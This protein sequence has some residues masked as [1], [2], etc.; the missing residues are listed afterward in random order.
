[1]PKRLVF[2]AASREDAKAIADHYWEAAGEQ[3]ALRF[4]DA[5]Q[6]TYL[7]IEKNPLLGSMRYSV[8][9]NMPGLRSRRIPRFPYLVFYAVE[10]ERIQ[11]ARIL[12]E[13]R[14]LPAILRPL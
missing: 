2:R 8:V 7:S 13:R 12:H 10:E 3:I 5:L 6:H 4:I 11:V 9:A 14:D 1:M